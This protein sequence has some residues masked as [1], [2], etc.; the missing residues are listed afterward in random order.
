MTLRLDVYTMSK[1]MKYQH[2]MQKDNNQNNI[3][4]IHRYLKRSIFLQILEA[5]NKY[6]ITNLNIVPQFQDGLIF[7]FLLLHNSGRD[8]KP[9]IYVSGGSNICGKCVLN[10]RHNQTIRSEG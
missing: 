8:F 6:V 2:L 10:M 1:F 7:E 9:H 3:A 4:C 5:N